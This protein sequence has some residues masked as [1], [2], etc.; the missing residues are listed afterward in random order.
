MPSTSDDVSR[1]HFKLTGRKWD[2]SIFDLYSLAA[3]GHQMRMPVELMQ[4]F[5]PRVNLEIAVE[6]G[7]LRRMP[8]VRYSACNAI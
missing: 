1:A 5:L 4:V 2:V 7:A 8:S 6:A 3:E